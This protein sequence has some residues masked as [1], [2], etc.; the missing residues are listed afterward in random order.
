LVVVFND[1]SGSGSWTPP[2][3]FVERVEVNGQSLNDRLFV[4]DGPIGEQISTVSVAG[5]RKTTWLVALRRQTSLSLSDGQSSESGSL[6]P[7]VYS[8][9]EIIPP[10]WTLASATCSDGSPIDAIS[11]EIDERVTCTF[12]NVKDLP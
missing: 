10:G 11:V 12:L 2:A 7:G 5:T 6:A 3:G 4:T 9:S 8:I 1:R